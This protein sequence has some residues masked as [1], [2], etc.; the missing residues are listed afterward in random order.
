MTTA[1]A[2][3]TTASTTTA[4]LRARASELLGLFIRSTMT[5]IPPSSASSSAS[6][7]SLRSIVNWGRS[8]NAEAP[9]TRRRTDPHSPL[10]ESS[11]FQSKKT[12]PR[13]PVYVSLMQLL[14]RQPTVATRRHQNRAAHL[15]ACRCRIP[16]CIAA[17]NEIRSS[18][19]EILRLSSLRISK[20]GYKSCV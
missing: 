7:A 6:P 13:V 9:G 1:T 11:L 10:P 8:I 14:R 4:F 3:S 17:A 16:T 20:V 15:T 5:Q 18:K 19:S 12:F 2:A